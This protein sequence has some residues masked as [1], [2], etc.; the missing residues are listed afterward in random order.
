MRTACEPRTWESW[1]TDLEARGMLPVQSEAA[2]K[3]RAAEWSPL[4]SIKLLDTYEFV[5]AW[6]DELEMPIARCIQVPFMYW[7]HPSSGDEAVI[8]L[9]QYLVSLIVGF[10]ADLCRVAGV[11]EISEEAE[12]RSH[13]VQIEAREAFL[14]TLNDPGTAQS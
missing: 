12:Q 9:Y 8:G 5:V 7:P 11:R 14:A 13:R 3:R 4:I 6:S 1:R 2:R 10:G